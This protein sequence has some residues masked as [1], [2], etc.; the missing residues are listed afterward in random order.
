[1]DLRVTPT[2][3]ITLLLVAMAM[4]VVWSLARSRLD[5]NLP[6]LFYFALGLFLSLTTRHLDSFLYGGGLASALVL[7]FE[8]MNGIFTRVVLW[9]EM[10]ALTF[11]AYKLT[12]D[13]FGSA[14]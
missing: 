5:S 12:G 2:D 8:F 11:I 10:V 13:V 4:Y 9:L 7:R 1:M 6:L 14:F 3:V